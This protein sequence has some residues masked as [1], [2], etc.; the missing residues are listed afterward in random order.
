[1]LNFGLTVEQL[2]L[3]LEVAFP[4]QRPEPSDRMQHIMFNAGQRSVIEYIK[5]VI[6]D[7]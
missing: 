5:R 1:M 2:L 6:E 3:D 4:Q 7:E